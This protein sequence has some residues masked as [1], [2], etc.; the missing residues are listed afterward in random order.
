MH[1]Y[2]YTHIHSYTKGHC[3]ASVVG[4]V[5][6]ATLYY[7]LSNIL[8]YILV[9]TIDTYLLKHCLPHSPFPYVNGGPDVT[10]CEPGLLVTPTTILKSK[11]IDCSTP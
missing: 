7:M 10:V 4:T 2:T 6:G 9:V 3:C 8:T 1:T 11:T 5:D